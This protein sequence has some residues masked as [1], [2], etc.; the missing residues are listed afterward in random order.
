MR[1]RD[2]SHLTL[3]DAAGPVPEGADGHAGENDFIADKDQAMATAAG[4][5]AIGE[6]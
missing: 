1:M 2:L 3:M 5:G 4:A 6:D